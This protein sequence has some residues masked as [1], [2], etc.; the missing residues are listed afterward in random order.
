[1]LPR[2]TPASGSAEFYAAVASRCTAAA[3]RLELQRGH[4]WPGLVSE[5]F[6]T[7]TTSA[8]TVCVHRAH[9]TAPWD[10]IGRFNKIDM[11]A[12]SQII[13]ADGGIS[14]SNR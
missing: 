3:S 8:G 7:V 10:S 4:F 9:L 11:I 1:M 6:A 5:R 2:R 13:S 12:A 14:F